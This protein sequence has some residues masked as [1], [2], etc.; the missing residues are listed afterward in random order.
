MESSAPAP[1]EATRA[2]QEF[3]AL[4]VQDQT[5]FDA[6][7]AEFDVYSFRRAVVAAGLAR[8]FSF[9]EEEVRAGLLTARQT[10]RDRLNP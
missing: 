4:V 10:W 7:R 9:T 3:C 6:L 1:T 5:L 8:G 2:F